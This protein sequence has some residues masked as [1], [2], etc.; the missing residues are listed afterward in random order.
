MNIITH[1]Y[2][3]LKQC[4]D[5]KNNELLAFIINNQRIELSKYSSI[6]ISKF[7]H[8]QYLLD[9]S[10]KSV[11]KCINISCNNTIDI[12]SEFFKT[13]VLHY[14]NDKERNRDIFEFGRAFDIT[15][16]TNI[17][18]EYVKSTYKEINEENFYDIYDCSTF[19]N[20][21]NKMNECVSFFASRMSDLDEEYKIKTIK[22]Y[23]YD[24]F[25]SIL[26]SKSLK[27]SN[28][29]SLVNTIL[30]LSEDD[31]SFFNLLNHVRVEFCN[32]DSIKSI[33][34]FSDRNKL[35][36]IT[37]EVFERAL[38]HRSPILHNLSISD[39]NYF[40]RETVPNFKISNV[41]E[42]HV[43]D[44]TSEN[45][46][47]LKSLRKTSDDFDEIYSVLENASNEGDFST[48]KFAVDEKYSEITHSRSD[49]NMILGSAI[50]NNICLTKFLF[51]SG[52]DIRSKVF[53]GEG[54]L[55]IFCRNGNLEGVKFA[56][57]HIDINDRSSIG[58][59][60]LHLA[61][62]NNHDEICEYLRSQSNIDKNAKNY[63]NETALQYAIRLKREHIVEILRK[64]GFTE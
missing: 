22:R 58:G 18:C 34:N 9:I 10:V 27:I 57:K 8:D 7:V 51:I 54:I 42:H 4:N 62:N 17:F 63:I 33:K 59:T 64:N 1:E 44:H 61:I 29:D 47:N 5:I 14:E 50:K 24:F 19:Q 23:R 43:T 38:L 32:N 12:I 16:L 6:I 56:L 25:E 11:S 3:E 49:I 28:E 21:I 52:A 13:S 41:E 46:I 2:S 30:K 20:D 45:L 40:C 53:F 60:P 36:S 26:K 31:N 35:E 55:H 39:A 48:I 37:A 15:F